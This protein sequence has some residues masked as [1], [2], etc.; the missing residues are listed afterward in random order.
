MMKLTL[1]RIGDKSTVR[2]AVK[3]LSRYLKAA[4]PSL[5]VMERVYDAPDFT[6]PG[7]IWIGEDGSVEKSE[8]DEIRI[9]VKNGSGV[10]TGSSPRAVLIAVYRFLKEIGF[11]FLFPGKEGDVIPDKKW[12]ASDFCVSLQEK[13]SYRHRSVCIEGAIA[14]EHVYNMIDYLPKVG[15]N[16]YFVQFH[17][18][19]T[20]FDRFYNLYYNPNFKF[21]T[22]VTISDVKNMWKGLE[23]E[24]VLRG[25]DY[26][27]TGHGWTCDPFGV[28]GVGWTKEENGAPESIRPYLAEL[29]GVRDYRNGVALNTNLCYSNPEAREKMNNAI[30]EYVKKNP[31]VNY[32]HF[33]LADGTNNHCECAECQKMR[34]S[35]WYVKLLNELDEKLTAEGLDTKIVCLIYVDL[36]WAPEVEKIRN[37]QRFVLMFAPITRTYSNAFTDG[38]VTRRVETPPYKRNQNVMPRSVEENLSHLARWQ[39]EQLKGSESFDF[40]YHLM[41]DHFNDPGYYECA[42]I[43]HKD[44]ANLD[45]IG[46]DGMVSCQIQ[47]CCFPTGLP[48]Y[49]MASALWNKKSRFEDVAKEYFET[50]YGELGSKI[51]EYMATL[52]RLFDPVYLRNERPISQL[53]QQLANLEEVKKVIA[54]FKEE[55]ILPNEHRGFIWK[56]LTYHADICLHFADTYKVF[57]TTLDEEARDAA[58]DEVLNFIFE[59]EEN[60]HTVFDSQIFRRIFPRSLRKLSTGDTS[61]NGVQ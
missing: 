5:F 39:E 33:W 38:D 45:Q 59:I 52:S 20:F 55:V 31:A 30:V 3:E 25:L 26:H 27:A 40:D 56:N 49:A 21:D 41:W 57:M 18:P 8:L 24:I 50:A 4:D 60:F 29:N 12:T 46:L 14:Y 13:A 32:L 15:M 34:P 28:A 48:M 17:V 9:D 1:A 43:L 58:R 53:P 6:L 22:P 61:V 7:V 23:E 51:E 19:F 36:L 47:R 44:M 35:D 37:P 54:A 2:Y 42:R 11:A 10:I 16:G